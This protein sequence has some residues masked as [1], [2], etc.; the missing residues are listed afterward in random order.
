MWTHVDTCILPSTGSVGHGFDSHVH[1]SLSATRVQHGFGRLDLLNA[2][3][4]CCPPGLQ[5]TSVPTTLSSFL[6]F[7]ILY[8]RIIPCC[9]VGLQ[10]TSSVASPQGTKRSGSHASGSGG[11]PPRPGPHKAVRLDFDAQQHPAHPAQQ[12]R[13][14]QQAMAH[15]AAGAAGI[16][17]AFTTPTSSAAAC[18]SATG[19]TQREASRSLHSGVGTATATVSNSRGAGMGGA[20]GQP[21]VPSILT[22]GIPGISQSLAAVP[23]GVPHAGGMPL[24]GAQH[25]AA[26]AAH[27]GVGVPPAMAAASAVTSQ[28]LSAQAAQWFQMLQQWQVRAAV[29]GEAS[30]VAWR[31]FCCLPQ[32][33]VL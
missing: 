12:Q 10:G 8:R 24:A 1:T 21:S 3:L 6:S 31:R 18:P 23:S 9:L 19:D 4:P 29:P 22:S 32:S 2:T 30:A 28:A 33:C 26:V 17:A 27:V 7:T 16:L 5:G 11:L 20:T 14:S 13:G 25:A 15:A